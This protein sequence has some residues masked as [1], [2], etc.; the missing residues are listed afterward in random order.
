[1]M[2]WVKSFLVFAVMLVVLLF[3]VRSVAPDGIK[4]LFRA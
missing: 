2:G 3:I 1:M 4:N